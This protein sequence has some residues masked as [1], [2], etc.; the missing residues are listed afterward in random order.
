MLR[1]VKEKCN[2]FLK[3]IKVSIK[4]NKNEIK[5][6]NFLSLNNKKV[7]AKKLGIIYLNNYLIYTGH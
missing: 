5:I 4:T 2:S 1:G 6:I 3:N 7:K